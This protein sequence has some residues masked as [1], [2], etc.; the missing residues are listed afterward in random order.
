MRNSIIDNIQ[1]N[2]LSYW[3]PKIAAA[4]LPVPKTEVI[5][6]DVELRYLLD[7][8]EPEGYQEFLDLIV[9]AGDRI[10]WPFFFRT[11][12]TSGKH[13]WTHT[14]YVT[15]CEEEPSHVRALVEHS[16]MCG[17]L[18]L[19]YQV[20]CV[21]EMLPTIPACKLVSY[22]DMPLCRE[23]RLFTKAGLVQCC[24]GY[25]PFD[26]VEQGQPDDP[27]WRSLL[28]G[29]HLVSDQPV[30]TELVQRAAA[31]CT[32][33]DWSVDILET[34]RGWVITDMALAAESY[35][36]EGCTHAVSGENDA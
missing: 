25:W 22:G 16:E 26:A 36:W 34:R 3:Y 2:C 11:G 33:D 30:L 1:K 14:C 6:T 10:G 20:W 18:G 15:E 4:G 19:P 31:S 9:A 24:H 23:F 28:R 8:R 17:F 13:R 12:L 29:H 32:G 21:R 27:C 35:H 7:A 5:K